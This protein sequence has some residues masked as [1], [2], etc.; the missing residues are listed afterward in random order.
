M[1]NLDTQAAATQAAYYY[2]NLFAARESLDLLDVTTGVER[3]TVE[4]EGAPI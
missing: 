2:Q 1:T 4:M 3:V